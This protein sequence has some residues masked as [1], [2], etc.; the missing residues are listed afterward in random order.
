MFLRRVKWPGVDNSNNTM[1]SLLKALFDEEEEILPSSQPQ[2]KDVVER[3][4]VSEAEWLA[5][6]SN[7]RMRCVVDLTGEEDTR[8]GGPPQIKTAI[9]LHR[10]R[11]EKRKKA[12][13]ALDKYR[14]MLLQA[15]TI[16]K[17][18]FSST[19]R[20]DVKMKP[21]YNSA[22]LQRYLAIPLEKRP[23]P[24]APNRELLKKVPSSSAAF[25]WFDGRVTLFNEDS[26]PVKGFPMFKTMMQVPHVD[27]TWIRDNV[28]VFVPLK[29]WNSL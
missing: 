22:V 8:P 26:F 23:K 29:H 1:D 11:R 6:E 21:L 9:D 10:E 24:V 4:F 25:N 28:A 5:R 2:S 16:S 3:R 17:A 18:D 13:A 15:S 27:G 7:K 19:T 12:D 14:R 20:P